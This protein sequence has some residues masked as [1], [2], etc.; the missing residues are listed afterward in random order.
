MVKSRLVVGTLLLV[1]AASAT[2]AAQ[3][4]VPRGAQLVDSGSY[5]IFINGTRVATES[6][7]IHQH[8]SGSVTSVELRVEGADQVRE[9]SEL[10]M[11]ANGDLVRYQWNEAAP[12]KAT[13]TVEPSDVFLVGRVSMNPAEK[14]VDQPYLLPHSTAVLDDYIFT[15]RQILA[16]RYMAGGCRPSEGKLECSLA[17]AQFGALIPRQRISLS[18][19]LEYAGREKVAIRGVER[20]LNRFN[21][22]MEGE[23]W[24]LWL[25]DSNKMVRLL[26]PS[27]HTEVIRD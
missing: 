15:H 4:N 21:L 27:H 9:S 18:V 23:E 19:G 13:A 26:V 24:H 10:H 16:W 3:R 22:N 5:G 12:G 8:A 11:A 2:L 17:R 20:E 6:F 14:A 25:D 1:L 7:T